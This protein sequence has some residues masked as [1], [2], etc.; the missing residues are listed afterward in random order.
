MFEYH[1]VPRA[2]KDSK[3]VKTDA[4]T[5]RPSTSLSV[6]SSGHSGQSVACSSG[7]ACGLCQAVQSSC[8]KLFECQR[9]KILSRNSIYARC[10]I[11]SMAICSHNCFLRTANSLTY[12]FIVQQ[13][14]LHRRILLVYRHQVPLRPMVQPDLRLVRKFLVIV[15]RHTNTHVQWDTW[16]GV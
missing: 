15:K 14:V 8:T 5:P 6:S 2:G 12:F 7:G 9:N 4:Q 11:T 16:C 1:D 10:K 13:R 3:R